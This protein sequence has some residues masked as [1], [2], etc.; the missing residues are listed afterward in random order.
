MVLKRHLLILMALTTVG[1]VLGSVAYRQGLWVPNY[2]REKEFPVRGIDVS[3]HQGKIDWSKVDANAIDFVYIKA[4]EGSDHQDNQFASN[5]ADTRTH[6]IRRGAYHFFTLKTPGMEQAKN[7]IANVPKD[8]KALPPAIDLEFG[9]NSSARPQVVVFQKELRDF[10]DEI[11]RVYGTEPVI[12]TE[13]SFLQSYLKGFSS[14]RL[15]IRSVF[16]SPKS[17]NDWKFWQYSER[18]KVD[19]IDGFA[20]QNVFAG[21]KAEFD[22]FR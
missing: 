21:S 17:K 6:N 1:S 4:T 10:V 20:D 2:P 5:W 7:F 9:G 22:A 15:W 3:H 8:S 13:Y 18:R 12:Y 14:P 11:K 19:G 16:F